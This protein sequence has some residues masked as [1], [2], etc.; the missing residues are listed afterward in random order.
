MG[1]PKLKIFFSVLLLA[2]LCR[3]AA[4]VFIKFMRP[5]NAQYFIG[6]PEQ[7]IY[8]GDCS[9]LVLKI[10]SDKDCMARLIWM[11]L[12]D[13]QPIEQ[14]GII[15]SINRSADYREYVFDLASQSPYWDGFIKQI[16]VV[17]DCGAD[18][19]DISNSKAEPRGILTY[20]ASGWREFWGPDSRMIQGPSVNVMRTT[21]LW[22][23]PVNYYIY[24]LVLAAAA[25]MFCLS[26]VK[27]VDPAGAWSNAGKAAVISLLI[28]WGMLQVSITYN[29]YL[30]VKQDQREI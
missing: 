5:A 13:T 26:L 7:N 22:G 18:G 9:T 30:Q 2:L 23:I 1:Y 29:E 8:S 10:R 4:D 16:F 15:F 19:I 11:S 20:I 27:G 17:P 14:K 28:L 21:R 25:A 3:P 6:A 12:Q 24:I